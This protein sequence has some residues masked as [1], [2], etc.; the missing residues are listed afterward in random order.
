M[1]H[2]NG[3]IDGA[4]RQVHGHTY[5][6]LK[7]SVDSALSYETV[8]FQNSEEEPKTSKKRISLTAEVSGGVMI[9]LWRSTDKTFGMQMEA[10]P[11]LIGGVITAL[12]AI[13]VTSGVRRT[14]DK[15][16]IIR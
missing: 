7:K 4:D 8:R 15:N 6:R 3:L 14:T 9:F 10:V 5:F 13:C 16:V 11:Y 12:L 2:F 1:K